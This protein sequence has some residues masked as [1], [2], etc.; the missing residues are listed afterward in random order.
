MTK[1]V[2][3]VGPPDQPIAANGAAKVIPYPERL[4]EFARLGADVFRVNM[5][6]YRSRD[7]MNRGLRDGVFPA[8]RAIRKPVALMADLGPKLRIAGPSEK[9]ELTRGSRMTLHF[10]DLVPGS[11]Q[12]CSVMLYDEPFSELFERLEQTLRINPS[13]QLS[14]RKRGEGEFSLPASGAGESSKAQRLKSG[15]GESSKAQ[16]LKSG[17]GEGSKA[18]GFKS[19]A[20][21]LIAIGEDEV[22][23]SANRDGIDRDR[24]TLDCTVFR[25]G[26]L[27]GRKG[28]TFRDVTIKFPKY[29]TPEVKRQ[30]D[31]ALESGGEFMASI[32]LSFI[33]GPAEILE[34]RDY[35]R[36]LV[37]K[38]FQVSSSRFQ[39][40]ECEP[41]TCNLGPETL[42]AGICSPLLIAKIE[43]AEAVR[44]IDDILAVADGIM[45]ARGD[46]GLQIG[47]D[48]VPAVQKTIIRKCNALGKPVITATQMLQSMT[49]HPTPTRA[50]AA[51]VFNAILDG[52]D[53]IMLSNETSDGPFPYLAIKAAVGI[54]LQAEAF[55]SEVVDAASPPR[56]RQGPGR[57]G[58]AA[59]TH[60]EIL[61]DSALLAQ[62]MKQR[63]A[64]PGRAEELR[65]LE[66]QDVTDRIS[67][68]AFVLSGLAGVTAIIAPTT[69][70]RTPRMMSR[71]RPARVVIIGAAYD[72]YNYRKLLLSYAV[73]PI[74]IGTAFQTP[75]EMARRA[76]SVAVQAK[77]VKWSDRVVITS[78]HPLFTPGMTNDVRLAKCS[79]FR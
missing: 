71:F 74:W 57:G 24:G 2:V 60:L 38:Q 41:G 67:E 3:T 34:V 18:Q 43:T 52:S 50:E 48:R 28:I 31:F 63:L 16:R 25:A 4:D 26:R 9:V 6:F 76:I 13:P 58:D 22:I 23:L 14:P 72:R 73:R 61:R 15:A 37:R 69:T 55:Q 19:G 27:G 33:Q 62:A 35:I 49:E 70:G 8:V 59:S 53:A 65:L 75:S 7:E 79:E 11:R 77:L 47:T 36:R 56:D 32:A 45:I 12:D 44:R 29:L 64:G 39:V 66:L 51:D 21:I 40:P 54:A 5:A 46:L 78:G 1:V 20:E 10:R 30:I 68:A 17:A 42:P